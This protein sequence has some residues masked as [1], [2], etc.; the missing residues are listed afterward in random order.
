MNTKT[1][2][3]TARPAAGRVQIKQRK[4]GISPYI[5]ETVEMGGVKINELCILRIIQ[6][7]LLVLIML[8]DLNHRNRD[9]FILH[10]VNKAVF[11]VDAT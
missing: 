8:S 9:D 1:S 6:S 3:P 2:L 7:L 10:T 5:S 11:L 4:R